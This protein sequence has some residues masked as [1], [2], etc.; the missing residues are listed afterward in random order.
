MSLNTRVQIPQTD[1]LRSCVVS[2][3]GRV[4]RRQHVQI[5]EQGIPGIE[6]VMIATTPCK[7]LLVG[8]TFQT[9]QVDIPCSQN[10][11]IVFRKIVTH[12]SHQIYVIRHESGGQ[13][14]VCCTA[15]KG[16]VTTAER[17]FYVVESDRSNGEKAHGE[18]WVYGAVTPGR[19]TFL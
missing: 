17:C 14:Q 7:G 11:N 3:K 18:G 12:D 4:K 5:R 2:R 19:I 15:P 8:T 9:I 10:V 6:I 13:G 16:A 1:D